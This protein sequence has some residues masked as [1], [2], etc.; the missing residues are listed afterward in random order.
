MYLDGEFILDSC[1]EM[2]DKGQSLK[3]LSQSG[4]GRFM[5]LRFWKRTKQ[6]TDMSNV[7]YLPLEATSTWGSREYW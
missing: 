3:A 5:S 7:V 6:L 1:V 2:E 4:L